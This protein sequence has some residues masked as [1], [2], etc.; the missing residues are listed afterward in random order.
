VIHDYCKMQKGDYYFCGDPD[1]RIQQI[2]FFSAMVEAL[3][4]DPDVVFVCPALPFHDDEWCYKQHGREI[5]T[6][7][8]GLRISKYKALLAWS[9]GLWKGEW[10]A[11][12]PR[13]FKAVTPRYG[14]TEHADIA[15]MNAHG[16]KWLSLTDYF[17]HHQGADAVYCEWKHAAAKGET[18]LTFAEWMAKR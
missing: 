4:S 9:T 6:L 16:K 1:V 10:L 5:V 8:S 3:E 14:W 11:A 18:M 7:P 13:D 15:L 2:G 17:D 12:R